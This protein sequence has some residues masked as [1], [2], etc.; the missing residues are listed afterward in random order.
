[1]C[2]QEQL[3]AMRGP[4]VTR[5][6]FGKLGALATLAACTAP[7]EASAQQGRLSEAIAKFDAPGGK[8]DAFFIYPAEGKHPA[9]IVWPDIAGLRDAFMSTG[10]RLA[11][12]GYAV[13]ILNPY[14]RNAEAPQFDDFDD[15]RAQGGMEKVAPWR[16]QLT[17]ANVMETAKAVVG[18]LDAQDQIDTA[19]G[20]G[21]QG[22][23][24]GG[25]FTVWTAAAAPERVK[26]AASFHG[27]GLVGEDPAAP[28]KMLG[29]TQAS[30]LFAIARND[31]RTAPGDKDA[32]KAAATAAGRPAKV[33]VFRADH[34]WTVDDSPV[35]DADAADKAWDE[36]LDL[37]SKAL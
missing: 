22:Y 15:W 11:R 35:F 32:L 12:Q 19:K 28:V 33:E 4:A 37:Y 13:L 18:W 21:T 23:C 1:M 17:A 10:R 25:P 7:D 3:A 6:T 8:M 31:D 24:M 36:L 34:G 5:R 14:Y 26:A 30:F 29:Q 16:E 9:I 2:D 20:I 27:A